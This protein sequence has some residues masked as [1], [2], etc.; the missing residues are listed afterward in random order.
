[1]MKRTRTMV[2][3]GGVALVLAGT[4]AGVAAAQTSTPP[5]APTNSTAPTTATPKA[6]APGAKKHHGKGLAGR[7][8]HG[9]F[10]THT[11]TGDKVLD[12]QRGTVTGLKGGSITV[13]STDGFTA[14]YTTDQATKVRKDKKTAQVGQIAVNDR[15][16][17]VAVKSQT[18]DTVQHIGDAG[19]AE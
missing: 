16:R 8:E 19:P 5:P 6:H 7:A 18:A 17:L 3:A 11:K 1:M 13:R 9:E 2:A 12:V 15:V 10:T 4:G 14:T